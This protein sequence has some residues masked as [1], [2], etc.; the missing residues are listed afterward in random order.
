VTEASGYTKGEFD[1]DDLGEGDES[2][3]P[4]KAKAAPKKPTKGQIDYASMTF[5]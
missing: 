4:P 1:Q 3:P 5:P 2:M